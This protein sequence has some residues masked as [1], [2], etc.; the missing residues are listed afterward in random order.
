MNNRNHFLRA[1]SIMLLAIFFCFNSAFAQ[2]PKLFLKFVEKQNKIQSGY[3]KLQFT[4]LE[5]EDTIFMHR[6]DAFFISTPK[7]S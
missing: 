6:E 1:S 5:N 2:L 4:Y 3:V 7:L